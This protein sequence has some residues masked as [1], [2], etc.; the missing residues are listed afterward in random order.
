MSEWRE[1][2]LGRGLRVKHGWAFK[3]EHFRDSGEQIVLTPGNFHDGGGFKPKNGTE[4]FYD[5]AYPEQFLLKRGDVVTAMTEQAQGLLGSTATIPS[6]ETFLHNQRIGLVEITDPEVLDLRYVYHL[7]NAPMVRRQLQATAT[8]SKVRHTAPERIQ[9]VRVAVPDIPTQQVIAEVLDTVDVLIENNRRRVAVLQEMARAIYREWFVKFRYPGHE[10]VLLVDSAL[11]PIPEGWV[12]GTVGDALELKYGK[13]L[14]AAVRRGGEV[15]VVSSAGVV[16]WHDE[17]LVDGPAIVVG[18][19]GNV[20]SVHWV[21]GPC[22]P[23]DTAYY[24][25]TGLPLRFVVE[26]LRRTEFT[27]THAAVPGLSRDGAYARPFLIPPSDQLDNYQSIVDPLGA[28][29]S[30]LAKQSDSLG[31][32]RD[33]LLPKLVTGQ[34]DVSALDL[35]AL[36]QEGVGS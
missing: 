3:G 24:V 17:S 8:G 13:A 22:W 18:R 25:A 14:K 16:G 10:D 34:I 5:G 28:E 1:L 7:M 19:K 30:A 33:L 32:L 21:D 15:A 26:Q 20:G 9:D 12:A 29:A 2:E 27:N 31:S 35:D 6:D 4:K 11:G 36:V 23:I